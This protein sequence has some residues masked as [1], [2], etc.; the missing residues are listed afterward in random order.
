M[1]TNL[2][3][4][5]SE[6]STMLL[7]LIVGIIFRLI[8]KKKG[9]LKHIGICLGVL[10]VALG[11][12]FICER[13][14][15]VEGDTIEIEVK[16]G[17]KMHNPK[18]MYHFK[19]V[20]NDVK[21]IDNNINYEKVGTYEIEYEI[22]TWLG[23]CIKKEKVNIVDTL[24][25]EITLE[26]GED[27]KQSY[28]K[29]YEEPGV[30]AVDLNDGELSDRIQ[31]NKNEIDDLNFEI[32]Y[33][34]QDLAGNKAEKTRHVTIVDD[35]EPDITLNGQETVYVVLNE[36]YS[37][38][39][40]TAKDEKDGD[41]TDDIETSGEVDTS[42]EGTYTIVYKVSDKSGNEAKKERKVK[43]QK[44]ETIAAQNGSSG[45]KGVI[46]LTFDDGPTTDITPKILDILKEKNVPAT[47]FILNYDDSKEY[48]IKR[49]YNEGHT[50]AIHG[51]SHEYKS[52]YKSEEAF[53]ENITKLQD[54]I[55]NTTGYTA[56]IIRFP[57]GSSNT[58]S[59]FNPGIMTRLCKLVVD[60]GFRYFDWNVNSGDADTARTSSD[61]YNNVTKSLSK[62]KANVVLMHDFKGNTKTL[63]AL[64]DIIDYGLA[65]GYT[66]ERITEST[67]MVTH[68][69]N[70]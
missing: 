70:N 56:K 13:P 36:K 66:F 39:G 49:E 37:D 8:K 12:T 48:L 43:V 59:R 29:E 11:A 24:P 26:G 63:N 10:I 34:V 68:K 38:K 23:K 40:A 50:V 62:S 51:Y 9:L 58:V 46:Y 61:V 45:K 4:Y 42:K 17:E 5:L 21:V 54:K 33:T 2:L 47:F 44:K 64:E 14:E 67:P 28:I 3:I 55:K 6:I 22:D 16:S 19:D 65:N 1:G 57:G 18:T 41:L 35:I 32:K 31:T 69:P 27:Y 20:T 60:K 15:V 25:P 53:M 52:I 7:I 30:K